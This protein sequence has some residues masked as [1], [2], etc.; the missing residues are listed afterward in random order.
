MSGVGLLSRSWKRPSEF[1]LPLGLIATPP[2][3]DTATLAQGK[4]QPGELD[5]TEDPP[6]PGPT[7][8]HAHGHAHIPHAP[9]DVRRVRTVGLVAL[10]WLLETRSAGRRDALPER[11]AAAG[12]AW[13]PGPW[14][15]SAS[16]T[17]CW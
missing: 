16:S 13:P 7:H 10:P 2:G 14:R 15:R 12:S 11:G 5:C 3:R 4:V 17:C 6:T 1:S 8:G 9:D